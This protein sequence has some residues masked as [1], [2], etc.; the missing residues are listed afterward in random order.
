MNV[1]EDE[2][3]FVV[4]LSAPGFKKEDFKVEVDNKTLTISGEQKEEK[5]ENEKTFRRKEFNY[6]SFRRSF[7]LPETI[8]DQDI[9]AKYDNGILKVRLPKKEEAKAKSTKVYK[10]N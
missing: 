3:V 8:N 5:E 10:R 2:N 9:D 4:E 6:G 1:S 7:S